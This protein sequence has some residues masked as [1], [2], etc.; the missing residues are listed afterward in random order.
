[1]CYSASMSAVQRSKGGSST[2]AAA[3]RAGDKIVD[4][5]TGEVHD[6]TKKSGVLNTHLMM[7]GGQSVDRGEFW[8]GVELHHKRGDAVT[9][10]ELRVAL[11]H[12]L[13]EPGRDLLR[14]ALAEAIGRYLVE[15]YGVAADVCVHAPDP[16]GDDR[17]VHVH[18]LMSACS[19]APDGTLGK[20]VVE[21]D[22]IH[23]QRH[24]ITNAA[25][26]LRPLWAQMYNNAL[27]DIGVDRRVDHRSHAA[28]GLDT[29]PGIH[30]GS[31]ASDMERKAKAAAEA[32]GREY[33][34]V[35]D[36]GRINHEIQQRNA[37]IIS[38][39][40]RIDVVERE[41]REAQLRKALFAQSAGQL[42][43][44]LQ[45][46]RDLGAYL[47]QDPRHGALLRR[48]NEAQRS[49]GYSAEYMGMCRDDLAKYEAAHPIRARA[50]RMGLRQ[51]EPEHARLLAAAS[52]ADA[53]KFADDAA[54]KAVK[55]EG[56]KVDRRL[57]EHFAAS[58]PERLAEAERIESVLN[59]PEYIQLEA[60]RAEAQQVRGLQ[61]EPAPESAPGPES[62]EQQLRGGDELVD[63]EDIEQL[64]DPAETDLDEFNDE[65]GGPSFG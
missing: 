28:R 16:G 6:Y 46:C 17:N 47:Q 38:I 23:C 25:D 33:Q 20:K 43:Q 55:A 56:G 48:Y 26:H 18:I 21:L 61:D 5:A 8:S 15:K 44:R 10:R 45:G 37:E 30:L 1:M 19:V 52:E 50:V 42:Q 63:L 27:A 31:A 60:E 59:D 53:R 39:T 3:Y 24:K 65:P 35:T 54:L 13:G 34:P 51:P 12:E 58:E 40:S 7:P 9:A 22:P 32:E 64:Q 57:R 62:D 11:P 4:Q 41:L 14:N 36:R 2:A 49:A 29:L